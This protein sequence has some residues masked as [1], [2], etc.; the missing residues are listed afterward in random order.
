[1]MT[2]D[3][4]SDTN[5]FFVY[6]HNHLDIFVSEVNESIADISTDLPCLCDLKNMGQLPIQP[7]LGGT[8][9]CVL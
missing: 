4:V 7:V 3:R 6:L 1:M 8:V 9:V 5:W 2:D